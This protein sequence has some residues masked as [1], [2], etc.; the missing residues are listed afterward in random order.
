MG[1]GFRGAFVISWAQTWID[2]YPAEDQK[3]TW[4]EGMGWS[5]HGRALPLEGDGAA[6][7]LTA[8]PDPRGSFVPARHGWCANCCSGPEP[9]PAD[10]AAEDGRSESFGGA[11]R[12]LR[13][14]SVS[15]PVRGRSSIEGRPPRR[16]CCSRATFPP[17]D[18]DLTR[19]AL[20]GADVA[21]HA[22]RTPLG[23]LF[24]AGHAAQDRCRRQADRG[25]RNPATAF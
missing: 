23:H 19:G 10:L 6:L 9:G 15:S 7:I 1:T 16:S 13:R 20:L 22:V 11:V 14:A 12:R 8:R 4:W 21:C 18:R 17:P 24:H 25:P 2:G 3:R 5:W